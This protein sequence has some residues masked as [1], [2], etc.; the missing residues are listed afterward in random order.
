MTT[1]PCRERGRN[2]RGFTVP[3]LLIVM[4]IVV[5]G[6]AIAVPHYVSAISR[7]RVD[8][9]A[10]RVVADLAHAQAD[11]KRTSQS[12]TVVFDAG[13]STVTVAGVANL[14]RPSADYLTRLADDPY[15]AQLYSVDFGGASQVVFSGYGVPS[16]TGTIVVQAGGVQKTV[17]VAALTGKATIQ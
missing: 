16:S 11:A 4:A 15:R 9:A 1:Q 3:E 6:A 7:F 14:D 17:V 8:V 5:I 10:R 12:R 13:A 2:R